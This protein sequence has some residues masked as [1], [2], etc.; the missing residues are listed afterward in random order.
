MI[1]P[2]YFIVYVLCWWNQELAYAAAS[3]CELATMAF[4]TA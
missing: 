4:V 3:F 2:N 1:E